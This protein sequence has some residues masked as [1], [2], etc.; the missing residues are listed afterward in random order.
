MKPKHTWL[1][2]A[3]CF[4]CVLIGFLIKIPK[5]LRGNDKLLHTAFYFC[6]AGFLQLFFPKKLLVICLFLLLFGIGIEYLQ[7]Y[8]NTITHTRI[9]GRFDREDIYANAKGLALYLPIGIVFWIWAER[10][11]KRQS[12]ALRF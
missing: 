4:I 10:R 2:L 6:A 8:S 3:I 1:V 9:H 12:S 7:E 5:P 11:K